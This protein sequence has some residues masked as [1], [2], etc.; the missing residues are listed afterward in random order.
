[1]IAVIRYALLKG[2]SFNDHFFLAIEVNSEEEVE[3]AF[4]K[5][6]NNATITNWYLFDPKDSLRKRR[7]E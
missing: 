6:I 5:R 7:K 4:N 1:M 2:N 3:E